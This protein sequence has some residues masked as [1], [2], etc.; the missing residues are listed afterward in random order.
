MRCTGL[1]RVLKVQKLTPQKAAVVASCQGRYKVENPLRALG[2]SC[3]DVV[4][5]GSEDTSFPH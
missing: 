2:S 3:N 4:S 1:G 5:G